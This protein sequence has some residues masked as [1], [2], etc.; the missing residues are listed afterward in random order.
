LSLDQ[1]T[2]QQIQNSKAR[3]VQSVQGT[4]AAL[5]Q[6]KKAKNN[7]TN[8][9]P[10]INWFDG[11]LRNG[12]Y[13]RVFAHCV[14]LDP[15]EL[16]VYSDGD[17]YTYY[18]ACALPSFGDLQP[19]NILRFFAYAHPHEKFQQLYPL[20]VDMRTPPAAAAYISFPPQTASQRDTEIESHLDVVKARTKY[21]DNLHKFEQ[22]VE[23]AYES[24]TEQARIGKASTELRDLLAGI[25]TK[26]APNSV[27]GVS[28][29]SVPPPVGE[30]G[31]ASLLQ[32][33]DTRPRVVPAQ[34]KEESSASAKPKKK[35]KGKIPK[36]IKDN[37]AKN[38]RRLLSKD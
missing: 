27:P 36:H 22:A 14:F 32:P 13:I 16:R 19:G 30:G 33:S 35:G 21:V 3:Y 2:I 26:V 18:S 38:L 10:V 8:Q 31:A 15:H 20:P 1:D 12:K 25:L 37:H 6:S 17:E 9:M 28:G 5:A 7:P 34:P 23:D 4:V 11:N 24:V 29:A